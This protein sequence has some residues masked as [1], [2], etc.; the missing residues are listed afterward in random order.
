[1]CAITVICLTACSSDDASVT[2]AEKA[3]GAMFERAHSPTLGPDTAPVTIVEFFDPACE[4]CRAF[5]P[6]VKEILK[7]HPDD[8]RLV[9]RYAAFHQGSETVVRLLEAARQQQVYQAVLETLLL[10]QQEWASHHSPN[11]DRA[12]ELAEQAGLNV[13]SAKAMLNSEEMDQLIAQEGA[14]LR[15]FKINQTPTFFVHGQPLEQHGPD[16]LY[17]L[18]IGELSKAQ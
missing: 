13:S 15:A 11:I 16:H 2:Q 18:V 5:Y 1:M 12:W 3:E 6:Y 14:D 4:A 17:Q 10:Q 8:V 7:R 9:I